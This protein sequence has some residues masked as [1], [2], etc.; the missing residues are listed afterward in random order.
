MIAR[1]TVV[2]P[3]PESSTHRSVVH[4]VMKYRARNHSIPTTP[5]T[6]KKAET[7]NSASFSLA[8]LTCV[9]FILSTLMYLEWQRE[10]PLY[11]KWMMQGPSVSCVASTARTAKFRTMNTTGSSIALGG[12][13]SG[14]S[15]RT[16]A[17]WLESCVPYSTG[18]GAGGARRRAFGSSQRSLGTSSTAASSEAYSRHRTAPGK[19]WIVRPRDAMRPSRWSS[20]KPEKAVK[21]KYCVAHSK[22]MQAV[23]CCFVVCLLM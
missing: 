6:V 10:D 17:A 3:S 2:M 15:T 4:G 23:R 21:P 1:P 14:I 16:A 19:E 20:E 13:W 5:S 11:R 12:G 9:P 22:L 8:G 7:K 18:L